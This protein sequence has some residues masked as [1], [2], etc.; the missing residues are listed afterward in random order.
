ML[1]VSTNS[2]SVEADRC[3]RGPFCWAKGC[4]LHAH[5]LS[6]HRV[7]PFKPHEQWPPPPR[8]WR[9]ITMSTSQVLGRHRPWIIR[10][11]QGVSDGTNPLYLH[12][13]PSASPTAAN[14]IS[15]SSACNR[16][17]ET[18]TP[19]HRRRSPTNMHRNHIRI[20]T[21]RVRITRYYRKCHTNRQ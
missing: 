10:K 14:T 12:T 19:P 20:S 3:L 16:S 6:G 4:A 5:G 17:L 13:T 8:N 9:E 11:S 15:P 7:E 2:K 1:A 18:F 21:R